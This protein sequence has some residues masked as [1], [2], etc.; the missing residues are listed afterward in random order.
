MKFEV[1]GNG[2]WISSGVND[3]WY[4]RRDGTIHRNLRPDFVDYFKSVSEAQEFLDNWL[5]QKG[6]ITKKQ[7]KEAAEI[8]DESAHACSINH[9]KQIVLAT[10]KEYEE[11]Y[12]KSNVNIC[13]DFCSLC[14]RHHHKQTICTLKENICTS[15]CISEWYKAAIHIYGGSKKEQIGML[16][17]L[18]ETYNK[19]FRS[20][21]MDNVE[22]RIEQNRRDQEK[23]REEEQRLLKEKKDK[24][25]YIFKAG[26]V[27]EHHGESIIGKRIILKRIILKG[28]KE[29]VAYDLY[30]VVVA[31]G[32]SSFE[33]LGYK[34]IGELKDL[35]K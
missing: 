11:A 18:I 27:V 5:P 15:E 35:L 26:D 31:R 25:G 22:A 12:N 2:S 17:K 24:E 29:L 28:E 10:N 30:G 13:A 6:W 9:W 23:L 33:Y 14:K 20:K 7:V 34:K 21:K 16:N 4:L 3:T 1:R 19:T 32:Q 8:S